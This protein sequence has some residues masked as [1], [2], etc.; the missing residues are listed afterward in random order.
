[1]SR[2]ETQ[3]ITDI[4]LNI[5]QFKLNG[6]VEYGEVQ[7]YFLDKPCL[8]NQPE[9]A[10]Q[11]GAYVVLSKYGPPN[12]DLLEESFHTLHACSYLGQESLVCVS[13]ASIITVVSMQ[14]LPPMTGDPD[15]LW[16]VVE[17]GGL[18]DA[19]LFGYEAPAN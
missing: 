9:S 10:Q 11:Q 5:L 4:F 18:D 17:K 16:F 13:V 8:D 7:F 6:K 2:Y 15:N 14:P 1:M 19:Q 3:F 12:E